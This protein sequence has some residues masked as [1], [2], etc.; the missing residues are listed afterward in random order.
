ML[1]ASAALI[2][3]C[4]AASAGPRFWDQLGHHCSGHHYPT[5]STCAC[6]SAGGLRGGGCVCASCHSFLSAWG[7]V[8]P[9]P[10]QTPCPVCPVPQSLYQS[11]PATPWRCSPKVLR[12]LHQVLPASST[13]S[14]ANTKSW[15][16]CCEVPIWLFCHSLLF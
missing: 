15:G 2:S 8:S 5:C 11:F 3:L 12:R 16:C 4:H 14:P 1:I 9:P 13:L 7:L 10:P 6:V